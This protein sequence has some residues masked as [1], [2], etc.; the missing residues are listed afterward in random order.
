MAEETTVTLETVGHVLAIG[1]N[2]PHKKNAFNIQMLRDLADA[3]TTLEDDDDLWCGYVFAH[4]GAFTAGLDLAEVGPAVAKGQLLFPP[5][6]VDPLDMHGARRRKKPIVMAVQGYCFTIG[7]ELLLAS[8]IRLASTDTV[9]T[10]LEVGR[11]IMPFG[12]A[13]LRFPSHCGW[14]NAMRWML[15]GE[16]F[17]AAEALRMSLVQETVAPEA[18]Y[19]RGLDLATLVAKQAPKAVQAT[20]ENSRI[21]MEQGTEAAKGQLMGV[22]RSLM[23]TKDA[24]EGIKSFIERREAKFTGE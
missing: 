17:D 19:Q 2:R 14:G 13:T 1:L 20:R 23:G 21:A 12:G 9:F 22:A 18:L 4:G 3:Y 5:D 24:Q 8:D 6:G 10:Q 15:T 11:G 16:R 7:I